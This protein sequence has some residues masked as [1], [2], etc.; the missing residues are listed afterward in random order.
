MALTNIV[1]PTSS[2][3]LFF[4][5][6]SA[7]NVGNISNIIFYGEMMIKLTLTG[8]GIKTFTF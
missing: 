7:G 4:N 3:G 1:Y 5:K 6:R 2:H 8:G